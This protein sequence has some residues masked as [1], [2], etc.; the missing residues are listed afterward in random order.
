MKKSI[1]DATPAEW[2]ALRKPPEH[3]TQGNIEV[4][5]VIR[6]T[7]D[8]EQFK[9]YCKGNVLKY[10]MRANHHRQPTVEHLRKARDYLNWWIDEEVQP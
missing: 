2:N 4:I 10:V 1:D 6:D 8:S 7:L 3:Y 9:G 5:E